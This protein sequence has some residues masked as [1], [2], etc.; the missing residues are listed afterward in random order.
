MSLVEYLKKI[1]NYALSLI[2]KYS[3]PLRP[4][5]IPFHQILN[6]KKCLYKNESRIIS[7]CMSPERDETK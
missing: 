2:K 5:L 4:N 6:R 7:G 3:K 1:S